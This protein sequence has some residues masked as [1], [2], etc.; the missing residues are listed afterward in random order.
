MPTIVR[1][2][3]FFVE[4]SGGRLD[5]VRVDVFDACTAVSSVVV[6]MGVLAGG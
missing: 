4:L 2:L 6:D 3:R 5:G 1:M